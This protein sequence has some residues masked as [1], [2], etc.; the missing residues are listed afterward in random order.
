MKLYIKF[1][2]KEFT[3]SFTFVFLIILSLVLILNVLNEIEFFKDKNVHTVL[4]LFLSLLNSPYLI[5]EIFPFI[6]FK[7]I[8][9]KFLNIQV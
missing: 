9:F 5:F 6:F 2:I 7:I 1:L 3:K 4:P 8:K